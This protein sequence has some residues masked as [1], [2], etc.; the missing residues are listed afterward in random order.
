MICISSTILSRSGCIFVFFALTFL[1]N[2]LASF[3]DVFDSAELIVRLKF[4][5]TVRIVSASISDF[6]SSIAA[7]SVANLILE[8]GRN[9]KDDVTFG[10]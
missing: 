5:V 7:L 3:G 2:F 4:W 6:G 9:A 1:I 8:L 10:F